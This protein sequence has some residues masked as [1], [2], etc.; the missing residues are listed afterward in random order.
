MS[1]IG[2][3]SLNHTVTAAMIGRELTKNMH[4]CP[5]GAELGG[6]SSPLVLTHEV[7]WRS[8]PYEGMAEGN[9]VRPE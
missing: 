6:S 3:Y 8:I 2:H 1:F 7:G 5:F 9:I 4:R